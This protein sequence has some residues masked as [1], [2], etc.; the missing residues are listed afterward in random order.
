[1]ESNFS[2]IDWTGEF[3]LPNKFDNKFF[4]KV[5][6]SPEKGII[7]LYQITDHEPPSESDMLYGVI[8]TGEPCTLIGKFSPSNS[9]FSFQN[10]LGTRNGKN[11]FYFLVVGVFLDEG[12][13]F[14]EVSFSLTGMQ[15]FFFPKGRKDLVKY[16]N[17]PLFSVKND[18][19]QIEVVN[20]ANFGMIGDD[21]TAQIYNEN[22]EA[23]DDLKRAF[24]EIN[25]KYDD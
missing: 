24:E 8:D 13:L 21:I 11:G 23:L 2:D 16:S 12:E 19:G 25:S 17:K 14:S 4:G 7:L 5:S 20:N 10:G 18:Y 3:F 6:F 1:M 15:E 9:G 22:D